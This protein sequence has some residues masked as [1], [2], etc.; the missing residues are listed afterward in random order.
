MIA[1]AVQLALGAG[2]ASSLV[3]QAEME[4]SAE[5]AYPHA[6]RAVY[7]RHASEGRQLENLAFEH[8]I[9]IVDGQGT[10]PDEVLREYLDRSHL[11]RHQ[12]ASMLPLEDYNRYRFDSQMYY[13]AAS[14]QKLYYSGSPAEIL[15]TVEDCTASDNSITV[16]GDASAAEV[17]DRFRLVSGATLIIDAIIATIDGSTNFTCR[18]KTLAALAAEGTDGTIYSTEDDTLVR[19]FTDVTTSTAS[20]NVTSATA[21]FT[22]ADL[23]R[24]LRIYQTDS[25]TVVVDSIIQEVVSA[26]EVRLGA[27]PLSSNLGNADGTIFYS[28]LVLQAVGIP[29][30]PSSLCTGMEL[31]PAIAEDTILKIASVLRGEMPLDTLINEATNN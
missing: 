2:G 12:F 13:Y 23:N 16:T 25:T 7:R 9:E 1:R 10:I 22:S 19:E 26:T 18:G 4:M 27:K 29:A 20:A 24:R 6:V 5:A 15:A 28:P 8:L 17:G 31:P 3:K 21:A 11:P 30:L 14:G